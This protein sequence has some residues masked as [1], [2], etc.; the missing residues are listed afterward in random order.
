M[1]MKPKKPRSKMGRPPLGPGKAKSVKL[2]VR[3]TPGE[4][5][6]LQTEAKSRGLSLSDALMLSWRKEL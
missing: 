3:V 6:R 4:Y 2:T 1:G 5:A